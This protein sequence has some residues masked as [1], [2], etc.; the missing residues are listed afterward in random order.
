MIRA[1]HPASQEAG[2]EGTVETSL[3]SEGCAGPLFRAALIIFSPS[4]MGQKQTSS[5]GIIHVRSPSRGDTPKVLLRFFM[6]ACALWDHWLEGHA[7]SEAP[8]FTDA[9]R[10]AGKGDGAR[11]PASVASG[12]EITDISPLPTSTLERRALSVWKRKVGRHLLYAADERRSR[13]VEP[14]DAAR[15]YA[16][17]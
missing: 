3:I 17:Y 11:R 6:S 4:G 2:A 15:H 5:P 8:S 13:S 1:C 7:S 16:A 9:W 10:G 12:R 14:S